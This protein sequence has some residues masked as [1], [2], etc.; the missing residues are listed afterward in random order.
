MK[1][2]YTSLLLILLSLG[3]LAKDPIFEIGG[4]IVDQTLTPPGHLFYEELTAGW[5]P[6]SPS[7]VITVKERPD[8][9]GGNIIWIDVDDEVV[10][11]EQV[12]LRSN[13]IA[14]KALE[15]RTIVESYLHSKV[16]ALRGLDFY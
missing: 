3:A 8:R 15:A 4:L 5:E 11:E 6:S 16:E 12:G 13:G 10:F 1:Y 2:V 7:S 14:E 9:M